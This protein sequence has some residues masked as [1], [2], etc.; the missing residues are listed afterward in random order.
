MAADPAETPVPV[1][2]LPATAIPPAVTPVARRQ[3]RRWVPASIAVVLGALLG[4]LLLAW[5]PGV[6]AT[7]PNPEALRAYKQAEF[8][9]NAGRVQI[10]SGIRYYQE[11]I[12]LD[13]AFAEAWSG[14]A[15]AHFAQTWFA[16]VPAKETMAQARREAQ[17]AMRLDP[18]LSGPWR[19]LGAISHYYD[20]DHA[21]AER[22]FRK[23]IELDPDSGVALSWFAEFL[24]DLGRFDEAA[25]YV[26]RSH[27][28][29]PRW[30]EPITVSGNVH[31]F[32][33]HPAL[34]IAEY[35][36]ALAIEPNFG[37][38]NHF[39]GQAFLA[40]GEHQNAI[41]QLRRSN[42]LMGQVP[43]TLGA[44]GHALAVT[45]ARDQAEEILVELMEK[46][47]QGFY[48]AFPIAAIH[49]GLGRREA[50]LDWLE[51]ASQER[52][53][54]YYLPS[55]DPTYEPLRSDARFKTL[56]QRMNLGHQ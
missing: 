53:M 44:L 7:V 47:Q 23:A 3:V 41:E 34:A 25:A 38:A 46:R 33:G 35:R 51:R 52:H 45:G 10:Q 42:D 11:A 28:A 16:D 31:A 24:I 54:G 30:L 14:L 1:A 6:S 49:M 29:T 37:L 39:L 20:W 27:E 43:F 19:V 21:A 15:S 56:M 18:S 17:R 4:G 12:R 50:A 36:R 22:Q 32:T 40:T 2:G 13:P 26:R 55:I 5:W 9:A 8:A 48:P